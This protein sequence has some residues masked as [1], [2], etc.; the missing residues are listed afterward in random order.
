MNW[1]F[2]QICRLLFQYDYTKIQR[3]K[4]RK[5]GRCTKVAPT[6]KAHAGP[7]LEGNRKKLWHRIRKA[8]I[9]WS[10]RPRDGNWGERD[11]ELESEQPLL[12]RR[13]V[14]NKIKIMQNTVENCKHKRWS[15]FHLLVFYSIL[16]WSF[17]LF[18]WPL[19]K[20][21]Q[22]L[23][24]LICTSSPIFVPWFSGLFRSSFLI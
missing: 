15:L 5:M 14:T 20:G 11:S 4:P 6:F 1:L 13:Q 12:A 10:T 8:Y 18:A 22:S 7:L 24:W 17:Y 23:F 3:P 19:A 16:I 21:A 9:E 2:L